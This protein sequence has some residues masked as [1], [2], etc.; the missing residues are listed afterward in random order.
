M[1][2]GGHYCTP[3]FHSTLDAQEQQQQQMQ[4]KAKWKSSAPQP[5]CCLLP[6][7]FCFKRLIDSAFYFVEW[8][9]S[10]THHNNMCI[11]NRKARDMVRYRG[12]MVGWSEQR[13]YRVNEWNGQRHQ[14]LIQQM[15]SRRRKLHS[16]KTQMNLVFI[17]IKAV[18]KLHSYLQLF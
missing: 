5:R 13:Y 15:K 4:L 12:E 17:S 3:Q 2:F 6:L 18:R 8:K 16:R 14:W 9:W 7:L 11:V 1:R 10:K